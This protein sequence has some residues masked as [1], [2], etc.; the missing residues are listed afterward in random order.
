MDNQFT[1]IINLLGE[2]KTQKI[3]E[4]TVMIIGLGG[5]GGYAVESLVR[6]GIQKIIL[7]D[8]DVVD[9]TN[10]NRQIIANYQTI[11]KSKC[12]VMEER[13]K[14]INPSVMVKTYEMFLTPE[15]LTTIFAEKVDYVIDAIDT[16]ATKVAL[17]KYCQGNNI[18]VVSSLGMARRLDP[19]KVYLTKLSKTENDPMAKALRHLSRKNEVSLNIDVVCSKELPY[20]ASLKEKTQLGSMIFVPAAAG[21]LCGYQVIKDMIDNE[22]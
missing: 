12:Q 11:A 2:E 3:Q 22:E 6:S 9:I 8:K 1:R 4:R 16:M 15:N 20:E 14:T 5:V 18:K 19:S 7:V 21:L 17:W 10:L 13:M